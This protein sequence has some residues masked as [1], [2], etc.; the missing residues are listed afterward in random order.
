MDSPCECDIVNDDGLCVNLAAVWKR[1]S[2]VAETNANGSRVY[3]AH[4]DQPTDGTYVA[5]FIDVQYQRCDQKLDWG[6]DGS[7]PHDI[8]GMLYFTT[9]V[10]VWPNTFPYKDCSGADC[11]GTLV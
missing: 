10:S 7:V 2:L 6:R 8:P 1:K 11:Y 9:Q 5:Y 4:M 3:V